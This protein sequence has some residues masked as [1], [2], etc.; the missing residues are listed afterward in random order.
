M[1]SLA[2]PEFEYAVVKKPTPQTQD[3]KGQLAWTGSKFQF[4]CER[5]THKVVMHGKAN[6]KVDKLVDMFRNRAADYVRGPRPFIN[7]RVKAVLEFA[8]IQIGRKAWE[9]H[10]YLRIYEL[11]V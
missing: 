7:C 10:S 3:F 9:R 11:Y 4:Q 2:T 8:D 1:A 5:A 6:E